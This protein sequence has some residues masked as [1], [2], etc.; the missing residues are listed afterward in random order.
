MERNE[1]SG[2]HAA[3]AFGAVPGSSKGKTS[4][5]GHAGNLFE[6]YLDWFRDAVNGV[7]GWHHDGVEP[8][9]CPG[10]GFGL[11]AT[12]DIEAGAGIIEIP[13]EHCQ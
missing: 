6:G 5:S 9:E 4:A 13:L 12:A 3:Q 2:A 11:V 8:T 10:M 1:S 7:G